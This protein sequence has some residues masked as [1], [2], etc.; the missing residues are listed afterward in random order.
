MQLDGHKDQL[1]VI[2]GYMF[3]FPAQFTGYGSLVL[4][5][6]SGVVLLLPLFS[7]ATDLS[8]QE[9][10]G[11]QIIQQPDFL[12]P[13]D[14]PRDY[15]SDKLVSFAKDVDRFF[16]GERNFQETNKS[17]IQLD[18]TRL[19]E[20]AGNNKNAFTGRI[21]LNLP[22]TEER[23]HLLIESD[24]EKK[25]TTPTGQTA[26][27]ATAATTPE[28]YA[29][30]LRLEKSREEARAW[31]FSTDAGLRFQGINLRPF[32][33]SRASLALPLEDW[34]MTVAETL[35]WFNTIGAG[36]TTQLDFERFWSEAV[37]LRSTSI[38]TW[39]HD[40][41]GFDGGQ[42]LSAF[43][44]LDERRALMYQASVV[45]VSRP[46]WQVTDYVLLMSYRYRLHREWM[47]FEVS[48]QLHFPKA[49]NYRLSPQLIMRLGILFDES[50]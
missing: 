21:K 9:A 13:I 29:A 1:I 3:F 40:R 42:S 4:R 37:L 18:F 22:T 50:R 43:H 8:A 47:F 19:M 11:K 7:F 35:F 2:F 15:I 39:L 46:Q 23:L 27:T 14:A 5:W 44:T 38:L 34:R 33:R 12:T 28:S 25:T 48:P 41:Q 49:G 32:A 6:S 20:P 17:V 26:P 45:G 31:H 16:G 10:P 30:A 36:E 24:P